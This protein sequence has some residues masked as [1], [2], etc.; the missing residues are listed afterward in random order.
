MKKDN[1]LRILSFYDIGKQFIF[2]SF[3]N[4]LLSEK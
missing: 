2:E 1:E 3:R 4:A